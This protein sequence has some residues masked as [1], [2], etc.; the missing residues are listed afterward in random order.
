MLYYEEKVHVIDVSQSL[1]N[2][3]PHAFDFLRRDII[4]INDF[5][6]KK[7]VHIFSD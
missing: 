2:D 3:H 7:R 6:K 4:N 5:F 1:E